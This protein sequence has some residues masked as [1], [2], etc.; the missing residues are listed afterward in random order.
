[1]NRKSN[2]I[3][4][5]FIFTLLFFTFLFQINWIVA[6]LPD[7]TDTKILDSF[8][9][10]ELL[11]KEDLK[12]TEAALQ[13]AKD[14]DFPEGEQQ[15]LQQLIQLHKNAGNVSLSLRYALENLNLLEEDA[16]DLEKFAALETIGNI[17]FEEKLFDNALT[18]YR[19]AVNL[20]TSNFD[21]KVVL[22]EKIGHA[23]Q[24]S[25]ELDSALIFF[26]NAVY[27]HEIQKNYDGQIRSSQSIATIYEKQKNCK[28]AL[29]QNLKIQTLVISVNRSNLMGTIAN[30]VGY[31][32]HCLQDFENAILNFQ[33]AEIVCE[34]QDCTI[35][36]I[37]LQ[38]NMSIAYFNLGDF[39]N[40]KLRLENALD[41]ARNV[42]NRERIAALTHLKATIFF[43]QKDWYQA[44][45]FNQEA[46]ALAKKGNH[47]EVLKDSYQLAARISQELYEFETALDFY[48]LHLSLRDSLLLE[49]RLRQQ[50]LLQQK[51]LLE[52][53]EK[54][55]KLLLVNQEVQD[56]NIRELEKQREILRLE[57]DKLSLESSRKENELTLL[58]QEQEI[59]EERLKTQEL[60]AAR[61][62]QQLQLTRQQLDAA[63]KD[64][65]IAQLQQK[66]ALQQ[67][68]IAQKE[69]EEKERNA[70]IENLKNLQ[71]ID[72]LQI[73]QAKTMNRLF[74]GA[75]LGLL[76]I[77]GL[78]LF[79]FFNAQKKSL[80]LAQQNKKIE[81]QK[82]QLEKS[83]DLVEKERVKS[84]N[85]LLNILP[86]ET[87][88][89][90][91]ENGVAVP[92]IYEKVSVLFTDFVG[93]T[94]IS[95]NMPPAEVI[96]ELNTCF[97]AFDEIIERHHLE[98]I[99][100]IGD[101]Y[102]CAGGVPKKDDNNAQNAVAAA[103]EMQIFINHRYAE[104]TELGIPYW[105]MRVGIHTGNIVAGVVGSKKF[106]YDIWGDTVNLASRMEQSAEA[107]KVNI[108]A[109]TYTMV[110][111]RF[112]CEFRGVL[113]VKNRG[114]VEM[115]FVKNS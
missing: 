97:L 37:A 82:S 91:K 9:V 89:E 70:E 5:K 44:Q 30:N 76:A 27:F 68:Q 96:A 109:A 55:I 59:K 92:Q 105:K 54:E 24:Q 56:L 115:Y 43:R 40:G 39:V 108:S 95:E 71:E 60:E 19:Q 57:S 80:K 83:R 104:K 6:Q 17:Y 35:D 87:A 100:T 62:K 73:E 78:V 7:S 98:K 49:E 34:T 12:S 1:M 64:R 46:I 23:Y 79:G 28:K 63:E 65:S 31:N 32:Y 90:L 21:K 22:L 36:K 20:T 61:S 77:I 16:D 99:K 52:R 47:A 114:E 93:F 14:I 25:F 26:K 66:E 110:R 111:Q 18:Y 69:A 72:R 94:R 48:G 51:F 11:K 101:A 13:L 33:Q 75:G 45:I 38:S 53:S 29:E 106:A 67:Q 58:K 113:E 41:L 103:L 88:K 8:S 42:K 15:A 81:A 74:F 84:E 2:I 10:K 112:L 85:L 50:E 4:G 102:M 3:R 86:A 107:G